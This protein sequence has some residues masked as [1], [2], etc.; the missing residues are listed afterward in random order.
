MLRRD[1]GADVTLEAGPYGSFKVTVGDETV[2]D[3]G[4]LAFLGVLPTLNEIR[5]QVAARRDV[6][7][8]GER[9]RD[10]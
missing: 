9:D 3:G 5:P 8:A 10:A 1:L 2:V 6:K 7:A 4:P